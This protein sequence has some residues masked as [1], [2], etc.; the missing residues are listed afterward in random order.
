MKQYNS[1]ID[2]NREYCRYTEKQ[3]H[4]KELS[5]IKRHINFVRSEFSIKIDNIINLLIKNGFVAD[6]DSINKTSLKLKGVIACEI[7][8]CN[9]LLLTEILVSDVLNVLTVEELIAFMSVF[10]QLDTID[11][12]LNEN[13]IVISSNLEN[14]IK[15]VSELSNNYRKDEEICGLCW[16]S[17]NWKINLDFVLPAYEWACGKTVKE[18]FEMTN[19]YE[20]NFMRGMI[21]IN[22]M[23]NDVIKICDIVRNDEWKKKLLC[24][25]K[26]IIRDVVA[27]ESLYIN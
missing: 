6:S 16:V 11:S 19:I 18:V 14:V 15:Y 21:K 9:E 26:L 4:E 24:V 7:N 20:G 2:F 23:C 5:D 22:N 3:R 1:D 25:E 10:M 13:R 12:D 8:E 17:T 27:I